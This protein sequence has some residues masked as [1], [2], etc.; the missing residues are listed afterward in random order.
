MD[1]ALKANIKELIKSK[2]GFEFEA[3]INEMHL[4]QYGANGYQSTRERSDDGAEGIILSS[5]T[6]IAAYGPD[7]YKENSFL[8]KIN[9]DFEDFMNKW[10]KDNPNW[11]MYYNNSLAPEQ[12]RI[13][14]DLIE[15]AKKKFLTID[16]VIIKGI[17]QIMYLI[18]SDFTNKQQRQLATIL[19]VPKELM[20]FDHIRSI[21]DDLIRGVGIDEENVKYK[22][23][24]DVPEKIRLNYSEGDVKIAE[25]EY[26][27]LNADG[28]LKKIWNIIATYEPEQINSL[29]LRIKS[30]FNTING[31]FKEKLNGLTEKYLDKY[32]SGQDDDFEYY[33]RALLVYCFEQCMIGEK[34]INE[35]EN[36]K[37]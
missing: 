36:S 22:I 27:D 30:E 12:I 21:I 20:I 28:T 7:T 33:T 15:L 2:R 5:R 16:K 24:V 29:K 19:G 17:D 11:N 34:L 26:I 9:D 10:A 35:K 14:D 13:S 23:A 18:E 3:F 32:T 4:I 6:I 8:K 1:K 31:T 25:E 37:L